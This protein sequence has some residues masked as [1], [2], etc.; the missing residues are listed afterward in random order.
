MM[1]D[2]NLKIFDKHGTEIIGK[3]DINTGLNIRKLY[4]KPVSVGLFETETLILL[5]ELEGGTLVPISHNLKNFRLDVS[6]LNSSTDLLGEFIETKEN[7][8]N[9]QLDESDLSNTR[10]GLGEFNETEYIK[11]FKLLLYID[12][13]T[14]SDLRMFQVKNN[15]L[16]WTNKILI[17]ENTEN[18]CY[19]HLG[20]CGDKEGVYE[21]DLYIC[22]VRTDANIPDDIT[23]DEDITVLEKIIIQGT[24]LGEDERYR[25]M[26]TNFGVPDPKTYLDVFKDNDEIVEDELYHKYDDNIDYDFLNNKSKK[27]FLTYS[28]IFPYVG[29]YKALINAV[30]FLGYD[31]IYFKE[32]YKEL[33]QISGKAAKAVSYEVAYKNPN[34]M[35]TKLPLDRRISMKKL[36]WLSMVYKITEYA[37][38]EYGEQTYEYLDDNVQIPLLKNNYSKYQ[39]DE[40]LIKLIGL[41]EW[42]E[43]NIIAL[44]CRIIEINGEGIVIERYKHRIYGKTTIGTSYEKEKSLTPFVANNP[45]EFSLIDS[46]CKIKLGLQEQFTDASFA[47]NYK[48]VLFKANITTKNG[49]LPKKITKVSKITG[50]ENS[51]GL[52][53]NMSIL[54]KDGEIFFDPRDILLSKSGKAEAVFS[55]MP[56]IQI[57][58]ANIRST[59]KSWAKSIEYTIDNNGPDNTPY[60]FIRTQKKLKD[61]NI[62]YSKD[63]IALRPLSNAEFKYSDDNIFEIPLFMFKNFD[64]GGV[65]SDK[66]RELFLDKEYILEIL[67]GKLIFND[68]SLAVRSDETYSDKTAKTISINFNFDDGNAEQNI[69]LNYTYTKNVSEEELKNFKSKDYL[70]DLTV[71]NSGDYNI[72]VIATDEYNNM[73]ANSLLQPVHIIIPDPVL[74]SY[75]N[76][77]NSSNAKDFHTVN[78]DGELHSKSELIAPYNDNNVQ[79]IFSESYMS[80]DITVVDDEKNGKMIK[81]VTYPTISYALDTPK[82]GDYVH[83]M[84][85]SDRFNLIKYE[86]VSHSDYVKIWLKH[87]D[88]FTPNTL[89]TGDIDSNIKNFDKLSPSNL[90]IYDKLHN[91]IVYQQY[92]DLFYDE[93][94]EL[95]YITINYNNLKTI[96]LYYKNNKGELESYRHDTN[97]DY[98]VSTRILID[99]KDSV[100]NLTTI[101]DILETANDMF[102]FYMQPAYKIPILSIDCSSIITV[103]N[104][105]VPNLKSLFKSNDIIKLDLSFN[106]G[107]DRTFK[108]TG[109]YKIE[110]IENDKIKICT[111]IL[112]Y[113]KE[114]DSSISITISHANCAY[115]DYNMIADSATE[116]SNGITHLYVKDDMLLNYVDNTYSLTTRPFKKEN[117]YVY[118]MPG[119]YNHREGYIPEISLN[120]DIY[121]YDIPVTLSQNKN[122]ALL[123]SC[124][125]D[126]NGKLVYSFYNNEDSNYIH[127]QWKVY[128]YDKYLNRKVLLFESW[129]DALFLKLTDEGV[130]SISLCMYDNYG[131]IAEKHFGEFIKVI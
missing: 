120:N 27:L 91:E 15:E 33:P 101:V 84:N 26:F 110:K 107:D 65:L 58:R 18:D 111:P 78:K 30:K 64:D 29:T 6:Q 79:C 82:E 93:T 83:F 62:F 8:K 43:K 31:D 131:N 100:E 112:S 70:T 128:K 3:T 85:I 98:D 47:E 76:Q 105:Y 103:D 95:N 87:N 72:T 116:Y 49:A 55:K 117:A 53:D 92:V 115:V 52:I 10:Y 94:R 69:E 118:W 113:N 126:Y 125:Y 90:V 5:N 119:Y 102:T 130:Y 25:H 127:I 50:E 46:S 32:W 106:R 99:T 121:K 39:S 114:T 57:E 89:N 129:N 88:S 74:Y 80:N 97:G 108:S 73:F 20:F 63:Y 44:N 42:L 104:E 51:Y 28:E 75:A 48:S 11:P 45:N 71:N 109:S 2:L 56:L 59:K 17:G 13:E 60:R 22:A 68:D 123:P 67:D 35:L 14:Q 38:D 86:Y 9:F 16:I 37:L 34:S 81:Y 122:I 7:Q 66:E 77:S 36:N 21:T 54:I 124:E 12:N 96:Y 4:L 1:N 24:A 41:K 23:D 19:I 40:I 61:N